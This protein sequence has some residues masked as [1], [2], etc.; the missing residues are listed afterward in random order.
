MRSKLNLK[1]VIAGATGVVLLYFIGGWVE[2]PI[3]WIFSLYVLSI[4]ATIW[5]AIRILKDPYSTDRTF[6]ETFYLDRPDMRRLETSERQAEP[7]IADE[8]PANS[9]G[10]G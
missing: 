7:R 10:A 2:L 6:E 5:M 8:R 3:A 1:S 9:R 4:G